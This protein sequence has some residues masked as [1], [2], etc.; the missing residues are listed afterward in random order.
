[1]K[2]VNHP[3]VEA[4]FT[5][6]ICR[7]PICSAC[8]LDSDGE[9]HICISCTGKQYQKENVEKLQQAEMMR[10]ER[11]QL[12]SR[13]AK[14]ILAA[15]FFIIST[16]IYVSTIE[17][18][19]EPFNPDT[20][21]ASEITEYCMMALEDIAMMYD[22]RTILSRSTIEQA[23]VRPLTIYEESDRFIIV[24]PDPVTYEFNKMTI[25]RKDIYLEIE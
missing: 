1:M 4:D 15:V 11:K 17:P 13:K 22:E 6:S 3:G 25:T 24:S 23:C 18:P 8:E 2:C 19:P 12:L 20:A 9:K 21:T 5:C 14:I 10:E 7:R 16:V